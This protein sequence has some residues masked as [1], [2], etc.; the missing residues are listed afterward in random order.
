MGVKTIH[1]HQPPH[2]F[3]HLSLSPRPKHKS[4]HQTPYLLGDGAFPLYLAA[5]SFLHALVTLALLH[6]FMC[7][8]ALVALP[9]EHDELADSLGEFLPGRVA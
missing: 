9:N 8:D 6:L 7:L 5:R 2:T 1:A 4:K 3:T